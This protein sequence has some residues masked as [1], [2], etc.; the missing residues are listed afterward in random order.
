[1]CDEN[2]T[3]S[4][5][6]NKNIT[7]EG[8]G[9]PT[10]RGHTEITGATATLKWLNLEPGSMFGTALG[11]YNGTATVHSC[12]IKKGPY[13][14]WYG[15]WCSN[16]TLKHRYG[17]VFSQSN[18]TNTSIFLI[19]A[20]SSSYIEDCTIKPGNGIAIDGTAD[21]YAQDCDIV[22]YYRDAGYDINA[23]F[24]DAGTFELDDNSYGSSQSI[25]DPTPYNVSGDDWPPSLAKSVLVTKSTSSNNGIDDLD[26]LLNQ[27][28]SLIAL[29]KFD[30]GT[31]ILKSIISNYPD[32]SAALSALHK[33]V[34]YRN[35]RDLVEGDKIYSMEN[36]SDLA[37]LQRK[38]SDNHPLKLKALEY[39]I[40]NDVRLGNI[41]QAINNSF[42]FSEKY[43]HLENGRRVL[44]GIADIFHFVTKD[45]TAEKKIYELFLEK[46]PDH[47]MS[48]Y[49]K[50]KLE[51]QPPP[52]T[53]NVNPEAEPTFSIYPNPFNL[54]TQIKFQN[55]ETTIVN[56][57][58][59]N[60]MGQRIK[61]LVN[62]SLPE[63]LNTV[64][65]D[66]LNE[67]GDVVATGLYFCRLKTDKNIF[68]QK[69]LLVK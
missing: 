67:S 38:F 6:I 29:G 5:T 60:S 58:I 63:G 52:Q 36:Q 26:N 55:S 10:I 41:D 31:D 13:T 54:E 20:G 45:E 25:Y 43:M 56:L 23:Y 17:S 47:Q 61:Q 33:L 4:V 15:I 48:E 39:E 14:G 44:L 46:Y 1:L 40:N 32:E 64:A 24:T 59:Y 21:G 68:T 34:S 53:Q 16:S 30:E 18:S 37:G 11:I 19:N 2:V 69:I 65:W 7:L 62:K 42:E 66:G 9:S 3:E 8:S 51:N 49:V 12:N 50:L 22:T 28:D 35:E 27:A 57:S